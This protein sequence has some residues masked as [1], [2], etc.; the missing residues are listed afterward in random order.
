MAGLR[1]GLF[2]SWEIGPRCESLIDRHGCGRYRQSCDGN[3]CKC[4]GTQYRGWLDG[5]HRSPWAVRIISV[6]LR[7][8]EF[9]CFFDP[10]V[11]CQFLP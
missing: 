6:I 1:L 3:P 11:I 4:S 10:S 9:V 7:E 5:H 2:G 8:Y